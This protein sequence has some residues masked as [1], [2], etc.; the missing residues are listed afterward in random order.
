MRNK[1]LRTTRADNE[2]HTT[3]T[4]R[5]YQFKHTRVSDTCDTLRERDGGVASEVVLRSTLDK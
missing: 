3:N 5:A 2:D 4:N 1:K